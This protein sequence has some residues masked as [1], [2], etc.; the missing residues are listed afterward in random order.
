MTSIQILFVDVFVNKDGTETFIHFET[1]YQR[2]FF[3]F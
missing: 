2:I 3:V 1:V